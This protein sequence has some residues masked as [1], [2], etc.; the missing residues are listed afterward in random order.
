[1]PAPTGGVT[2]DLATQDNTATTAN[3][4][5]VARSLTAQTI[6]AGQQTYILSVVV[7][8]D[9][10]IENDETFFVNVTNVS[11]ATL[12]DGQGVATIQ[13]DDLP[14]LSI[15]DVTLSE[16][17]SGTKLFTFTVSLSAAA[18]SGGVTFAIATQDDTATVADSDYVSRSLNGQT[19]PA[20]QQTYNFDVTVNGDLNIEPNETF[21]V[22]VTNV[23]GATISDGQGV[24]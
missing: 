10:A 7:N 15:D 4:D 18:P 16:G 5:Y 22:N 17:N 11:G 20:G 23:S 1:M 12:L 9:T 14:T 24:G 21:F 2:F 8:G 19:I 6:P 13:N 3:S